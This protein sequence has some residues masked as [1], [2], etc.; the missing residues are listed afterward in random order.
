MVSSCT[1]C[2]G[3]YAVINCLHNCVRS[4]QVQALTVPNHQRSMTEFADHPSGAVRGIQCCLYCFLF[5][6]SL[7]AACTRQFLFNVFSS[8]GCGQKPG[9]RQDPGGYER[10]YS[11]KQGMKALKLHHKCGSVTKAIQTLGY[12]S[13]EMLYH[14]EKSSDG[15]E[16]REHLGA[17]A[18]YPLKRRKIS[19][20]SLLTTRALHNSFMIQ[21]KKR[22][23]SI[24]QHLL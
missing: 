10:M 20:C 2:S 5:K 8:R 16:L 12:P 11:K 13:K 9:L 23:H 4:Y 15:K 7:A 1:S 21:H 18:I 14:W 22:C 19:W 24:E 17:C 6:D 3:K